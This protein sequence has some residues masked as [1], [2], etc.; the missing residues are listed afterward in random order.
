[1]K[2]YEIDPLKCEQCGKTM[3]IIAY[4]KY[5]KSLATFFQ[6]HALATNFPGSSYSPSRILA[7]SL[8]LDRKSFESLLVNNPQIL[9]SDFTQ[10]EF[11]PELHFYSL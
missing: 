10:C 11:F 2:V 4:I 8:H 9:F 3:K 7:E 6:N 1:M 5:R